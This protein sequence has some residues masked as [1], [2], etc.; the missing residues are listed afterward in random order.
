MLEK[1]V[2]R[3]IRNYLYNPCRELSIPY[4]K[5]KLITL[6]S[7]IAIIHADD[8]CNQ[9]QQ[10]QRYF[11]ILHKL[12]DIKEVCN[13][14]CLIDFN[15]DKKSLIQMINK[16]YEHENIFVDEGDIDKWM[17][18]P[19]FNKS[20]WVKIEK[21]NKIVASGIAEYDLELKEGIIE[22]VQVLPEY[23]NKGYGKDIVNYLLK[24]LKELNAN[25]VTVS[26]SLENKT[27]PEVLY[28]KCGFIGN[29]V[30]YICKK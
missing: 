8:F 28:R 30:W 20:L 6:P 5:H 18:H 23:R 25:F 16:C 13:K 27:N 14:V 1:N 17:R 9:Y 7:N 2:N 24:Q 10:Y 11:R 26:G 3:E 4:W 12:V 19:T 21:N 29:D 15:Y 22:W